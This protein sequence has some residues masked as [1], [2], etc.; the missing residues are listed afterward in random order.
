V[1]APR[2]FFARRPII[3]RPRFLPLFTLSGVEGQQH[4]RADWRAP[5]AYCGLGPAALAG[6][7][8]SDALR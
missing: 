8:H 2:I 4:L 6:D 1:S 7:L 3:I 5:I